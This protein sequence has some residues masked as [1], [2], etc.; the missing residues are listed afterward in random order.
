MDLKSATSVHQECNRKECM[1][2]VC[3]P[4][5][6]CTYAL[7]RFR[8]PSV[9]QEC[10]PTGVQHYHNMALWTP[11][12]GRLLAAAEW[13]PTGA[14]QFTDTQLEVLFNAWAL[15]TRESG[16][17]PSDEA[18]DDCEQLREAGWLTRRMLDNGDASYWWTPQAELALDLHDLT[19]DVDARQ[20]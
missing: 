10:I 14:M 4:I 15:N 5:R 3:I 11:P 6:D 12:A 1:Q 20:N 19:K 2:Q 13:L 17:V 16:F 8:A 7:F 9:H 18:L